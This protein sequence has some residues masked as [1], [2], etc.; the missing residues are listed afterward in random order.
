MSIQ[1]FKAVI[2]R[3][4]ADE[5][6][7]QQLLRDAPAA[8][9]EYDLTGIE[10]EALTRG[11]W[12]KHKSA[13]G[14]APSLEFTAAEPKTLD[15]E[16]MFDLFE[17][18]STIQDDYDRFASK[19]AHISKSMHHDIKTFDDFDAFGKVEHEIEVDRETGEMTDISPLRRL[20]NQLL[21]G[22]MSDDEKT[23][24][25][26]NIQYDSPGQ[27]VSYDETTHEAGIDTEKKPTRRGGIGAL[28][29]LLFLLLLLCVC[30]TP[31][32]ARMDTP[33]APYFKPLY[34][35]VGPV[36]DPI[37]DPF[38]PGN[39]PGSCECGGTTLFCEG[40]YEVANF[41]CC[42]DWPNEDAA[43]VGHDLVC[44][45]GETYED[46]EGCG[47][48]PPPDTVTPTPVPGGGQQGGEPV[49]DPQT[50]CGDGRCDPVCENEENCPADCILPDDPCAEHGGVQYEGEVCVC[51]GVIDIVIV[52]QDG[53]KFDNVTTVPCTPD[54]QACPDEEDGGDGGQCQ[55]TLR[56]CVARGYTGF[57]EKT[58]TCTGQP[59]V[60]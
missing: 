59:G 29:L 35:L 30:L 2:H 9:S 1:N 57:D 45:N 41:P 11:P 10:I 12:T 28:L 7:A 50:T 52:C 23:Y 40:G 49:C 13:E 3:A 55:L 8:L 24:E 31:V 19:L 26:S 33:A 47:G 36:L 60:P 22:A 21:R 16:L 20:L 15:V 43:C 17:D 6:F 14:D 51:A 34:E 39:E 48:T 25:K 5:R 37:Y 18:D 54:P 56:D 58:C 53:T 44:D 27:E 42:A 32:L 4:L 46:F 38:F